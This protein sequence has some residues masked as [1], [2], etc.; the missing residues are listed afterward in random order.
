M[1]RPRLISGSFATRHYLIARL[2]HHPWPPKIR[3]WAS[4]ALM[5]ITTHVLGAIIAYLIMR[6]QGWG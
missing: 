5:G 3:K 4:L 2:A 1:K 6:H